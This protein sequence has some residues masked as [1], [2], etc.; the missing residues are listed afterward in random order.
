MG[1][2]AEHFPN[3]VVLIGETISLFFSQLNLVGIFTHHFF[4]MNIVVEPSAGSANIA[5]EYVRG[6]GHACRTRSTDVDVEKVSGLPNIKRALG[7]LFALL[8]I[9]GTILPLDVKAYFHLEAALLIF[10]GTFSYVLLVNN[11]KK[12][13]TKIGDGAV[14]FGWLGLLFAWIYIA[15]NGFSEFDPQQLGVSIAYSMHPLLY[16]YVIKLLSLT[17]EI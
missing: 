13:A 10:A 9:F 11:E 7:A 8:T 17:F 6:A 16:G 4:V 3:L 2:K 5:S 1:L 12:L 15:Y 14:F